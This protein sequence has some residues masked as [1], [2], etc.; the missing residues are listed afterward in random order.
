MSV[1]FCDVGV[2]FVLHCALY[3]DLR[4]H[5]LG[6]MQASN[7]DLFWLSKNDTFSCLFNVEMFVLARFIENV[8]QLRQN[9]LY[10]S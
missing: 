1:C 9:T 2:Q 10:L 8:W 6:K 7:P 5:L 4:N 3:N